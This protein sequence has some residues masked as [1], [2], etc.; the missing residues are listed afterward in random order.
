MKRGQRMEMEG[1]DKKCK[2]RYWTNVHYGRMLDGVI[3]DN[4]LYIIFL[5]D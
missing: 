5:K 3:L 2:S 4:L 1:V